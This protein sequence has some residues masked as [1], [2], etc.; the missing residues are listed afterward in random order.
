MSIIKK[1]VNHQW[2][3]IESRD[4]YLYSNEFGRV[5]LEPVTAFMPVSLISIDKLTEIKD[6]L[7]TLEE[8]EQV[9]LIT[10]N[11]R[12]SM[13][14]SFSLK[15]NKSVCIVQYSSANRAAV[16]RVIFDG[17]NT[18]SGLSAQEQIKCMSSSY[19]SHE[20]LSIK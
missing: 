5:T 11:K 18:S 2:A 1:S 4:P 16:C 15:S 8:A 10:E 7:L 13:C 14:F 17:F 3:A 19:T 20:I 9:A 6:V 12:V